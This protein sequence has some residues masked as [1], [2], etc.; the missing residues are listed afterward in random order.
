MASS[1]NLSLTDEL[2]DFRAAWE[3]DI[4]SIKNPLKERVFEYGAQKRT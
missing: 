3:S 1:M 4:R 2:R